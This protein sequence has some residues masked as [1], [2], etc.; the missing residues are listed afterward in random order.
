MVLASLVNMPV[1]CARAIFV[2]HQIAARFQRDAYSKK[3]YRRGFSLIGIAGELN[4]VPI[5]PSGTEV[6][7]RPSTA[8]GQKV[9]GVPLDL[10]VGV[11]GLLLVVDDNDYSCG[12]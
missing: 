11:E 7:P 1:T 2:S 9:R 5:T 8:R 4:K 10:G 3:A 6:K 12:S